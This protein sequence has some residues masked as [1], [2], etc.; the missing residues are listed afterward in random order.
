MHTSPVH[1]L[2]P[3][4]QNESVTRRTY[5]ALRR[6]LLRGEIQPGERLLESALAEQL[7][8]S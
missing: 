7:G 5:Q 1:T 8:V 3:I 4:A 2:Q 6:A